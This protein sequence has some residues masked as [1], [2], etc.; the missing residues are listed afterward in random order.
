[1]SFTLNKGV[2]EIE[3]FNITKLNFIICDFIYTILNSIV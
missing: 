1:M 2:N 3:F